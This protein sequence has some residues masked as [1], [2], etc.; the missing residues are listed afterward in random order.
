MILARDSKGR[1][2][3]SPKNDE[4]VN[5][6]VKKRP[7]AATPAQIQTIQKKPSAAVFNKRLNCKTRFQLALPVESDSK[8][9]TICPSCNCPFGI[10]TSIVSSAAQQA[11]HPWTRCDHFQAVK[12]LSRANGRFGVHSV[13]SAV[14]DSIVT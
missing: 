4:N 7:S 12:E 9:W 11:N 1:F 10:A 5:D 14:G 8:T 13:P 3:R 6:V 2:C